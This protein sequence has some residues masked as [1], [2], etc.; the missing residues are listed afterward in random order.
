MLTFIWE[1]TI[2]EVIEEVRNILRASF[3][4][5][6]NFGDRCWILTTF[7]SLCFLKGLRTV[8]VEHTEKNEGWMN[9]PWYRWGLFSS[10]LIISLG[11]LVYHVLMSHGMI[12]IVSSKTVLILFRSQAFGRG[13]SYTT[14]TV[15]CISIGVKFQSHYVSLMH[16]WCHSQHLHWLHWCE[17]AAFLADW[18]L[19][20]APNNLLFFRYGIRNSLLIAPMPTASTAQ[21]LGNNESIEPYTSNIYTRRVLSGEFQVRSQLDLQESFQKPVVGSE[22]QLK[23]SMSL[24]LSMGA[25]LW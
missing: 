20:P 25:K 6:E 24:L 11:K 18:S 14:H 4:P 7:T 22:C 9:V 23:F 13:A 15:S 2:K 5:M 1:L 10:H 19:V 21:I 17:V 12:R 3:F 16:V 8:I